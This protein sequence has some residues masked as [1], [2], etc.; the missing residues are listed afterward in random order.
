M[1]IFEYYRSAFASHLLLAFLKDTVTTLSKLQAAEENR[2]YNEAC[3]SCAA[4]G[5]FMVDVP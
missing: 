1:S 4:D 5:L 3:F 2:T